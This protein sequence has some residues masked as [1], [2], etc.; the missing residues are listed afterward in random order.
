VHAMLIAFFVTG[1]A[2]LEKASV[3][4]SLVMNTCREVS[5]AEKQ[6]SGIFLPETMLC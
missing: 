4:Y 1:Y 5:R 3:V 2:Y 6:G